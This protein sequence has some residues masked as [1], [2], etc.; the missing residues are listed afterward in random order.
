MVTRHDTQAHETHFYC[1]VETDSQRVYKGIG[2]KLANPHLQ[3]LSIPRFYYVHIVH[4]LPLE[5][6]TVVVFFH[7]N[8]I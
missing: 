4:N 8:P 2:Q 6:C 3:I 5:L 7:F 1:R